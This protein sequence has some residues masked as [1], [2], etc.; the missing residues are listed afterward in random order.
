M[1]Q[2]ETYKDSGIAWLGKIPRHWLCL[3]VKDFG[4][5]RSGDGLTLTEQSS[6]GVYEVWGGNGFVGYHNSYNENGNSIIIGRVGALC[7][8]VRLCKFPI[9]VTDNAMILTVNQD[10]SISFLYYSLRA[11]DLNKLNESNAQ[12]LITGTKVLNTFV[13]IPPHS[14]QVRIVEYLDAKCGDID[15]RIVVL[16]KEQKAYERLKVAVINRAVTEG[17]DPETPKRDSGLDWLGMI[18]EHWE[19]KRLKECFSMGK[20][21]SITKD[22]LRETGSSVISYGQI[23]AKNNSGVTIKQ[24]F[25]RYVDESYCLTNPQAI[26][27]KGGFIF[28]DTSEDVLGSGNC[29]YQDRDEVILGGYHTVILYPKESNDNKYLAYLFQTDKWR[30]QIRSNVYGIKVM[31]ITQTILG[32]CSI[33]LPPYSEQKAIAEYL[34]TKCAA[35]DAKIG[36]IAKRIEA[37]KRLK[38]ALINEVVTGKRAV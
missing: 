21:L 37:Y 27:P 17:L 7:G 26:V 14:E 16:E 4:K 3:R 9:F 23:H 15:N 18:P 24:D 5:T 6:D 2:Y 32:K 28:A 10:I 35:I 11:R 36:N 1:K 34:D 12:P 13:P 22:D 33:V 20:G 19:V 38:R 29:I 30:K 8:N 25:I 31:S